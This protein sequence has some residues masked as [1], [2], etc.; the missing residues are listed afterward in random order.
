MDLEESCFGPAVLRIRPGQEVTWRNLDPY[1]HVVT[2]V[3]MSWGGVEELSAGESV[4]YRFERAGVSPY[5]CYLH[6]GMVG[7]VVV[8]DG[9]PKG[10]ARDAAVFPAAGDPPSTAPAREDAAAP[11]EGAA[12]GAPAAERVAAPDG[13]PSTGRSLPALVGGAVAG[14]ALAGAIGLA[15]ARRLSRRPRGRALAS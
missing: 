5:A 14:L 15:A 7:A 8:G 13:A 1:P 12:A 9:F 10:D 3:A 4:S 6:P 2:G 11:V